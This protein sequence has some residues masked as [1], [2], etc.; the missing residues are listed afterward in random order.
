MSRKNHLKLLFLLLFAPLGVMAQNLITA[1]GSIV[2][3]SGEPMI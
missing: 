3:S 2:D 1:S